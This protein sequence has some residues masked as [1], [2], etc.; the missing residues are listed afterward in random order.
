MLQGGGAG[1]ALPP[2]QKT[3]LWCG[4]TP[5]GHP[6]APHHNQCAACACLAHF[7]PISNCFIYRVWQIVKQAHAGPRIAPRAF[8]I[9]SRIRNSLEVRLPFLV[10]CI[11]SEQ[12]THQYKE[13]S[14]DK[15]THTRQSATVQVNPKRVR[16]SAQLGCWWDLR[17]PTRSKY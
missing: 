6:A 17:Y 1:A 8:K 9:R 13:A 14:M 5:K 16:R 3:W 12:Q 11:G 15:T 4:A 7:C 10:Y 2:P